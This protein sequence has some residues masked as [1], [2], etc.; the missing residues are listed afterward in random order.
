MPVTNVRRC[1]AALRLLSEAD[2]YEQ[3]RCSPIKPLMSKMPSFQAERSADTF[4]LGCGDLLSLTEAACC[5]RYKG[6]LGCLALNADCCRQPALWWR[7]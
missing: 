3:C 1:T 2:Y 5:L 4:P 6:C 7:L